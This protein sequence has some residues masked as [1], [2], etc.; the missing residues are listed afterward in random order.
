MRTIVQLTTEEQAPFRRGLKLLRRILNNPKKFE[1][2][3][4]RGVKNIFVLS[5][6][7]NSPRWK[8]PFDLACLEKCGWIKAHEIDGHRFIYSNDLAQVEIAQVELSLLRSVLNNKDQFN[9]LAE[10]KPCMLHLS[11]PSDYK[12]FGPGILISGFIPEFSWP[13]ADWSINEEGNVYFH[14]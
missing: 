2:L 14:S 1:L 11:D 13:N 9:A 7:W 12:R 6:I 5:G 10:I 8:K 3:V 4:G